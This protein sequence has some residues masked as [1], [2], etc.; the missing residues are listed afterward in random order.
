VIRRVIN[1]RMKG[2]SICGGDAGSAWIGAE[3]PVED[4]VRENHGK[5]GKRSSAGLGMAIAGHACRIEGRHRDH[6][7]QAATSITGSELR[8][9]C[10][11]PFR[12]WTPH[13]LKVDRDRLTDCHEAWIFVRAMEL[14][15][16][17]T[18]EFGD[19]RF[20]TGVVTW[21]NSD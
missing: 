14:R 5:H 19:F 7:A 21:P 11:T 10:M 15:N 18:I 20:E 1:L 6:S 4:N 3:W 13:W 2:N 16:T 9:S 17:E 8:R 12:E